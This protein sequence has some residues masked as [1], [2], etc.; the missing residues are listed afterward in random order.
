MNLHPHPTKAGATMNTDEHI[1]PS[2]SSSVVQPDKMLLLNAN[3]SQEPTTPC[4]L[5][6]PNTCTKNST[7]FYEIPTSMQT[8]ILSDKE[9]SL[10]RNSNLTTPTNND[11][12]LA[13]Y[14]RQSS[15]VSN[16]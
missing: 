6:T 2:S 13:S 8:T 12:Q 14:Y 9:S 3:L 16:V 11:I 10:D 5:N 4:I 15:G 1:S 7:F